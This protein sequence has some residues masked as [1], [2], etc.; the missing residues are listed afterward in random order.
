M[1][2]LMTKGIHGILLGWAKERAE[3]CG[4]LLQPRI[5]A[6]ALRRVESCLHA[7]AHHIQSYGNRNITRRI[8][9]TQLTSI[10]A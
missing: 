3:E 6:I 4:L 10:G 8:E 1:R 7:I 9:T 5:D 2:V